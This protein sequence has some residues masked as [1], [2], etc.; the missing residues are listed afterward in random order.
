MQ[1]ENSYSY[2]ADIGLT[3]G[4]P[5][6]VRVVGGAGRVMR[7]APPPP[8]PVGPQVGEQVPPPVP[9]NL[10]CSTVNG[11]MPVPLSGSPAAFTAAPADNGYHP[12]WIVPSRRQLKGAARRD[13][14]PEVGQTRADCPTSL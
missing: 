6:L 7:V 3:V 2:P 13:V 12:Y 9:F 10:R 11:P 8:S 1:N 4:T 14:R 5:V